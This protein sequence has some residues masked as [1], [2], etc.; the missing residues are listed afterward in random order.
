MHYFSNVPEVTS[1]I[2][3][4]HICNKRFRL[5]IHMDKHIKTFHEDLKNRRCRFCN[6]IFCDPDY[7]KFHIAQAHKRSNK[8]KMIATMS[9][10]ANPMAQSPASKTIHNG[11]SPI[12]P[13]KLKNKRRLSLVAKFYKCDKC[14]MTFNNGADLGKHDIVKHSGFKCDQC[15]KYFTKE[16]LLKAHVANNHEVFK[17]QKCD[18]CDRTFENVFQLNFHLSNFHKI[19]TKAKKNE[20]DIEILD[21][22]ISKKYTIRNKYLCTKCNYFSYDRA[23]FSTH[24]Q[25]HST[26]GS[27]EE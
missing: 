11:F 19:D 24:S 27:H 8:A 2:H 25:S 15:N 10:I 5:S 3:R 9:Q 7:V 26:K 20:E 12:R 23:E 16:S 22:S 21:E 14:G 18:A 17:K 6:K 13:M 4:C 1:K